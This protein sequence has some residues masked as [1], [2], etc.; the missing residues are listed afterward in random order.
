MTA[1]LSARPT[2]GTPAPDASASPPLQVFSSVEDL[3]A[4][5]VVSGTLDAGAASR[6]AEELTSLVD[7]GVRALDVDLS[8]LEGCTV[9]HLMAL[10]DATQEIAE[11]GAVIHLD[12]DGDTRTVIDLIE[13]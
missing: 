5:V 4:H 7:D 1:S 12:S 2:D 11:R 3:A 8:G 9:D 10:V 13:R 6:V